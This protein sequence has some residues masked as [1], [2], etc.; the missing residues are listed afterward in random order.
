M[1]IGRAAHDRGP[2]GIEPIQPRSDIGNGAG[3]VTHNT[4]TARVYR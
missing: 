2:L 3:L 1:Q 4:V